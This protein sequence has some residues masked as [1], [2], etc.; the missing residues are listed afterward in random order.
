M[1]SLRRQTK[2]DILL[3]LFD[4]IGTKIP[5]E[6]V[7][8]ITG[9][10]NYDSLKAFLSYIRKSKHVCDESRIDVRIKDGDCIRIN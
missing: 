7:C 2:S 9:I 5:V 8:E 1:K 10:K 4:E 6:S 3:N